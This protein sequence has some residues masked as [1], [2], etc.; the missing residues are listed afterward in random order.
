MLA[1]ELGRRGVA[2]VL[3]DDKPGTAVAAQANATQAR[4]ME[5][6]RRLGFADEIRGLGLPPDYPT[7]IV[8]CTRYA[9]H[10]LA[11]FALPSAAEAKKKIMTL[12]GSWSAAELPHRISQKFVEAVL[13]RHADALPGVSL[14]YGWRMLSFT[15]HGDRVT[16][17]V[18]RTDG[19]ARTTIEADYLVGA[20]GGRSPVR[21]ALGIRYEG[22]SERIREFMGGRMYAVYLKAPHFYRDIGRKPAWMQISFNPDRRAFFVAIDGKSEFVL[23]AALKPGETEEGMDDARAIGLFHAAAGVET[24]ASVITRGGW[25]AGYTLVA[26]AFRRGRVFL[27]GDAAHL[28]TPAGGLGYNTAVEDAVNLGWKLAAVAKGEAPPELLDTYEAER[29]PLAVRNTRYARALA[30]SLGGLKAPAEI[31]DETPEGEA[32]RAAAGAYFDAH[33]RR[34]FD[35]P[36]ITFGGRYDGSPIVADDGTEPPPDAANLYVA[37]AK[38]GGRPPHMWLDDGRS[39]YDRFGFEWTLLRLGPAAPDASPLVEAARARGLDLTVLDLPDETARAL[40]SADLALIRPDQ[41]VAWRGDRVPEPRSL[42]DQL[43][44]DLASPSPRF[45]QRAING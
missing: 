27:G 8:Y 14:H 41:I 9:G 34:E 36:G 26:E 1:N 7:D 16:A 30:D 23:H 43:L 38:P 3:V 35:I 44:G 32:A 20:D 29:R 33:A 12:S 2:A 25:T 21:Q 39:L 45:S 24:P 28:F 6:F 5:H 15:D 10:E 18:E 17:E 37:T 40:Y 4:T 42:F 11:R 22:E 31:E 13:R 19:S